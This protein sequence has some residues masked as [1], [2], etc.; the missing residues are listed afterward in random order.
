MI[1]L[2]ENI[3][4]SQRVLLR[5]WRIRARQVGRDFGRGGTKDEALIPFLLQ[6]ARPTFFTRDLGFYDRRLTHGGYC[7]VTLEVGQYEAA[8]FTRRFLR[9]RAFDTSRKRMGTVARVS[10]TGIR[11][12]R[13]HAT[14]DEVLD[15]EA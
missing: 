13:L 5:V 10:H 6:L 15:W 7:L 14:D 11:R 9:H 12:W 3:P 8:S 1:V 2:D 4:E